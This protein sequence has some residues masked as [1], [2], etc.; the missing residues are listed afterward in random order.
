MKNIE[1]ILKQDRVILF[2]DVC[3]LC[4]GWA[5]WI[6]KVDKDYQF[7]LC[8]VQSETGQAILTH[9]TYP[10]DSF[11]TMIVIGDG[12]VYEKSDAFFSIMK[13]LGAPYNLLTIG[14]IIPGYIR[15]W[16]YDR[17]ALNRYQW[18]GR[19]DTCSI[20]LLLDEKRFI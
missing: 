8:S 9:L 14:K 20:D 6:I 3:R 15:N 18:F 5:K 17:I 4:N 13:T 1:D 16:L 7:K 2:D 11:D 12:Q 10:T 19:L